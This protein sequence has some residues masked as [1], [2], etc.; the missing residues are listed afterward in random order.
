MSGEIRV[1]VTV[2]P[3]RPEN[4]SGFEAQKADFLEIFTCARTAAARPRARRATHTLLGL[5]CFPAFTDRRNGM[6][7][8]MVDERVTLTSGECVSE[9]DRCVLTDAAQANVCHGD[10]SESMHHSSLL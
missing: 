1:P 8:D 10:E 5:T 4:F 6:L 9:L 3:A 2:R 7:A